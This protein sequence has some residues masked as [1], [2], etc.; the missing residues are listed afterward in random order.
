MSGAINKLFMKNNKKYLNRS[1]GLTLI[2]VI[3]AISVFSIVLLGSVGVMVSGITTRH[4]L[5]KQQQTMEEFSTAINLMAKR[6]RMSTLV[7]AGGGPFPGIKTGISVKD[8]NDSITY[9]YLFDSGT[10]RLLLGSEVLANNVV[11][12]FYVSANDP[13][14]ITISMKMADDSSNK[15]RIQTTV[16]TR[17]YVEQ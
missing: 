9:T 13:K 7:T 6:I 17:S 11:G 3:V 12:S 4:A 10:K 14:A 1:S 5:K 15:T 2:E 8:N 16:S